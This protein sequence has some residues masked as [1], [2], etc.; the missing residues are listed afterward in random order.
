MAVAGHPPGFLAWK[1]LLGVSVPSPAN[2]ARLPPSRHEYH[3]L[4]ALGLDGP[5]GTSKQ[6]L[7]SF[8]MELSS[9]GISAALRGVSVA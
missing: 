8:D 2:A 5:L 1:P 7:T 6:D 3:V 4:T 9:S